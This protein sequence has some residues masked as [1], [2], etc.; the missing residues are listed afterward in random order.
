M[1]EANLHLEKILG[2]LFSRCHHF[3]LYNA[4]PDA[5]TKTLQATA[6]YHINSHWLQLVCFSSR[7][8]LNWGDVSGAVYNEQVFRF[9]CQILFKIL[10]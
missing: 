8:K 2:M 3:T 6:L 10:F 4:T 1:G 9:L 7:K 5:L